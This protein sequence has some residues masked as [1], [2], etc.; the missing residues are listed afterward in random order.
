MI[1]RRY[2]LGPKIG[3]G[4]FGE[5]YRAADVQTGEQVAAKLE[6]KDTKHAQ[7]KYEY[8]VYESIKKGTGF[9]NIRY[10][11]STDKHNVMVM[12]LLGSS[13]E[14]LFSLCSRKFSLKT[15]LMLAIQL[16]KPLLLR[17]HLPLLPQ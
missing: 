14:A 16:V 9:P 17:I 3:A 4:S 12:D 10:F 13:L 5:I 8:S 7:L 6:T 1:G 2:C 15:V 11:G